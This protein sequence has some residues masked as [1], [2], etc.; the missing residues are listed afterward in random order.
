[1]AAYLRSTTKSQASLNFDST[2]PFDMEKNQY[3][4]VT[5]YHMFFG[6][7]LA[8]IHIKG[9]AATRHASLLRY[10]PNS[11]TDKDSNSMSAMDWK[12]TQL[13][14][15]IYAT[16]KLDV[17][18]NAWRCEHEAICRML[19]HLAGCVG[20][21]RWQTRT[22][23]KEICRLQHAERLRLVNERLTQAN[24]DAVLRKKMWIALSL[25]C[26]KDREREEKIEKERKNWRG[27]K[28]R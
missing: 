24:R 16:Y 20:A 25:L 23:G 13:H 12:L 9:A 21:Y 7:M 4:D 8:E 1:M 18:S 3:C 17:G 11:S 27:K 15:R 28:K 19:E 14:E 22:L 5:T 6:S 26:E 10:T 2:A